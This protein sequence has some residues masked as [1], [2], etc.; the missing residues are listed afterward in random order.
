[1]GISTGS[2]LSLFVFAALVIVTDVAMWA[3][4]VS[5]VLNVVTYV[6]M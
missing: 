5:E 2:V 3:N 4:V 1:M 6:A